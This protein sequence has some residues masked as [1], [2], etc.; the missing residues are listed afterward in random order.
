MV[1]RPAIIKRAFLVGVLTCQVLE[2]LYIISLDKRITYLHQYLN[3]AVDVMSK[4]EC[5]QMP[6]V[7]IVKPFDNAPL[8]P[9]PSSAQV[10]QLDAQ[11]DWN[12]HRNN[13]MYIGLFQ[14]SCVMYNSV[15]LEL[16][17]NNI[18]HNSVFQEQL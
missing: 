9:A 6:R 2:L 12:K 15:S 4:T 5:P 1:K 16:L 14:Q 7:I 13:T 11:Q 18:M 17:R 3:N 8:P 10:R